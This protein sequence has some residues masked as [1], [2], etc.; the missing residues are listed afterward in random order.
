MSLEFLR[1]KTVF[2][3]GG[4]GFVGGRLIEI[5]IQQL[6]ARVRLATR[7][8]FAGRGA[9]RAAAVGGEFF[10]GSI[11]DAKAMKEATKGC[12]IVF[13]CAY[14]SY[15]SLRDQRDVTVSG[16]RILAEAA[17]SN[18]I[19]RFVN[20]STLVACGS[21][22]PEIVDETFQCRKMWSWPYAVDKRDAEIE[23]QRVA[24]S[25]GMAAINLRLGPVYG[26][27][28]PAFTISPLKTLAASRLALVG[29]GSGLSG[30]V[31]VDD[32]V[33]AMLRAARSTQSGFDTYFI[34]G[35]DDVTWRQ[36][37]S[38]YCEMLGVDRLIEL[39]PDEHRRSNQRN[40]L[41]QIVKAVPAALRALERDPEVRQAVSQL[42]LSR[43]LYRL[44]QSRRPVATARP[45]A[46]ADNAGILALTTVPAM[47]LDYF[48]CRSKF[49]HRKA[50]ERLGYQPQF[51]LSK[52]M[53]LVQEWAKWAR[54]L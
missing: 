44:M 53:S 30:A 1:G 42:P 39:T 3:S 46:I 18:G 13:H 35:P 51:D 26:P 2:V 47:M 10:E 24:E 29:D 48:A 8:T 28:G 16:T 52:G 25:S 12:E 32:V 41:S 15:G 37:Y 17:A 21:D 14:G 4:T 50:T 6:G 11:T 40:P 33:K 19:Q 7:G 5:A 54:L 49:S 22:T 27:W 34:T 43:S 45:A 23:L 9:F 31:Y 36:F 20:L 38:A